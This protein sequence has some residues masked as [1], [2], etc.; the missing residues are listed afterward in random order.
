MRRRSIILLLLL[1]VACS[2]NEKANPNPS[3]SSGQDQNQFQTVIT[4]LH[5]PWDIEHEQATFFI[6]EREG[7]IVSWS[8]EKGMERL[9]VESEKEITQEGEGGLLGL[10]L[11]PNFAS[12]QQAFAYHTYRENGEFYNRVIVIE[13]QKERWMEVESLL[14]GIPGAQFHNGGRIEIGPDDKL[15]VTTGDA[16]Q[17]S[18]ARDVNR[19]SGKIL[20]MNLD[21]TVPDDNPF[22][23]SYVYSYGHRNPQ[24]LTWNEE[25]IMFASEHGPDNHD[26]VNI[27]KGGKDYGWPDFVGDEMGETVVAPLYQTGSDTWAPSGIVVYDG[28]LYLA[29]LRGTA[30]INLSFEGEDPHVVTD[31]FGRVRDVEVIAGTLYMITNNTDGRGSPKPED[32]R[33]LRYSP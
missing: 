11:D 20:R 10:R 6:S 21:G 9:P 26:E 30:L 33:L 23:S 19:L 4:E 15:Y 8:E 7:A 27:I 3:D 12:N 1:L 32:D 22:P 16:L 13:K 29:A 17:G 28:K 24:G 25:G 2:N 31:Q 18:T 14:E 5:S